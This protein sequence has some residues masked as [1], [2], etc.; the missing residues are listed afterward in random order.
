MRTSSHAVR[1]YYVL[2]M[3]DGSIVG[4]LHSGFFDISDAYFVL[5][6]SNFFD[7]LL[8]TLLATWELY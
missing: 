4:D 1:A 6:L 8:C 7:L 5:Y 2:L 3:R